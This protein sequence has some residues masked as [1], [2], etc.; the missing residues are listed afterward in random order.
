[1]NEQTQNNRQI[2]RFLK[3]YCNVMWTMNQ[4]CY[5]AAAL[6]FEFFNTFFP[7]SFDHSGENNYIIYL[8]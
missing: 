6:G 5:L 4:H 8:A 3:I 2:S 1:M 7:G